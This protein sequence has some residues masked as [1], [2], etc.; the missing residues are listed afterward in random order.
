M[1]IYAGGR[2]FGMFPPFH[3]FS[4]VVRDCLALDPKTG[5]GWYSPMR[6]IG[7]SVNTEVLSFPGLWLN[8]EYYNCVTQN[9]RLN[10]QKLFQL[11]QLFQRRMR[12]MR[13]R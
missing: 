4:Q 2:S 8:R 10:E 9:A 7:S 5:N 11:F 12:R 6:G 3:Q 1:Q 13:K